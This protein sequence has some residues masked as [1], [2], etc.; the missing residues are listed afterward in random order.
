MQDMES[1]ER[2][3]SMLE[4]HSDPTFR[5]RHYLTVVKAFKL[6][7]NIE[8]AKKMAREGLEKGWISDRV[9][10]SMLLGEEFL[11]PEGGSADG[12]GGGSGGAP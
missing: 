11:P 6:S 3:L 1:A 2:A 7:G 8:K 10:V 5:S 4:G 9:F 12:E